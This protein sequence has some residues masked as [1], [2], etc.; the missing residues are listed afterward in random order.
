LRSL[1]FFVGTVTIGIVAFLA[2][3]ISMISVRDMR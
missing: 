1:R 3:K 2:F